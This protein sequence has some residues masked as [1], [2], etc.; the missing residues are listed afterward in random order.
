MCSINFRGCTELN[1]NPMVTNNT[2]LMETAFTVSCGF[3]GNGVTS[4]ISA[5]DRSKTIKALVNENTKSRDLKPGHI[6]PL[7]EN[8]VVCLEE[9]DIRKLL[10]I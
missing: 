3:K 9:Q 10:L 6:F 5:S 8:L 2:E 1:L 4:G 7:V